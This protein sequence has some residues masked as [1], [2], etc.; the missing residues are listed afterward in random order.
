MGRSVKKR[1][2]WFSHTMCCLNMGFITLFIRRSFT[3]KLAI[4]ICLRLIFFKYTNDS[5]IIHT[6][7][8]WERGQERGHISSAH[9]PLNRD[10]GGLLPDAYL[11]LV[12]K[13]AAN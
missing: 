5:E 1:T 7:S 12:R 2:K 3:F 4:M 9:A 8:K 10:D 11:H 6:K 13:K